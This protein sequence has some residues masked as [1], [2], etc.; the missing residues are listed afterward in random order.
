M[1]RCHALSARQDGSRWSNRRGHALQQPAVGRR[2]GAAPSACGAEQGE[3][4]AA[5]FCVWEM[6]SQDVAE[7]EKPVA[8]VVSSRM[9]SSLEV[10]GQIRQERLRPVLFG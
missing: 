6:Y 2:S 5:I 10:S 3:V 1:Q 8:A 4:L 7:P 9:K